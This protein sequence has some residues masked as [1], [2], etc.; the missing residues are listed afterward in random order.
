M[1]PCY[2]FGSPRHGLCQICMQSWPLMLI[3]VPKIACIIF[4]IFCEL[5]S[6]PSKCRFDQ[7]KNLQ[8]RVRH[9][10]S[11]DSIFVALISKLARYEYRRTVQKTSFGKKSH[12][13]IFVLSLYSAKASLGRG[14]WNGMKGIVLEYSSLP[15]FGS[16]NGENGKLIPLFQSL[17]RREWNE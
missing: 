8:K 1:E 5:I 16:F 11:K 6:Q 3:L 14:E 2:L 15:L 13:H 4:V 17:S 7:I 9:R 12:I 10:F